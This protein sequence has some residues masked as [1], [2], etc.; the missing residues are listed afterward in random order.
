MRK[1]LSVGVE[2]SSEYLIPTRQ[3]YSH[4]NVL[5]VSSLNR[6]QLEMIE[7][8]TFKGIPKE[9]KLPNI[10]ENRYSLSNDGE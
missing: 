6:N 7:S 10:P 1:V 4:D 9:L 3:T 2:S 8:P 5:Q